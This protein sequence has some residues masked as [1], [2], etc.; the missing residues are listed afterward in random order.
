[1][2]DLLVPHAMTVHGSQTFKLVVACCPF[3]LVTLPLCIFRTRPQV[4]LDGIL[5]HGVYFLL[6]KQALQ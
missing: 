5:G 1:V 6:A 2:I 3:E 4:D